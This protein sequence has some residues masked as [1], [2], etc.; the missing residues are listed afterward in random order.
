MSRKSS[1]SQTAFCATARPLSRGMICRGG[2][3]MSLYLVFAV[4]AV[5]PQPDPEIPPIAPIR[6]EDRLFMPYVDLL[7]PATYSHG[8]IGSLRSRL[9]QE[10]DEKIKASGKTEKQWKSE[11]AAARAELEELNRSGSVDTPGN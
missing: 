1:H 10:R 3:V 6:L 7:E 2:F 5:V 11:L 8:E 9:E 4:L